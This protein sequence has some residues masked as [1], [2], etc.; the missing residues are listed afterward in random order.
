MWIS[1]AATTVLAHLIYSFGTIDLKYPRYIMESTPTFSRWRPHPWHGLAAGHDPPHLLHAYIEMTPYDVMKYEIDKVT[2]YTWV[3]RPQRTSSQPPTLYGFVPRTYCGPRV[4]ALSPKAR[5]G[6]NDPLDICVI[7]ERPVTRAEILLNVRVVGGLQM[8]DEGESDDKIVSILED[9]PAWDDVQDVSELPDALIERL[10]HYFSTY[11]LVPGEPP[12]GSIE[13]IYGAEKAEKVVQA[14][15]K[16]Y[17]E[18]L[19]PKIAT[20]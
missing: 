1:C 6:D 11:K 13:T 19:S 10:R 2:G 8:V 18:E 17:E 20:M 5:K 3:D 12:H 15:I 16:D 14:A 9:D 7:S 4:A